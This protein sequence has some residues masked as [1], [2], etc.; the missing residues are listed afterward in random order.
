MMKVP[1]PSWLNVYRCV[2]QIWLFQLMGSFL[3]RNRE[4]HDLELHSLDYW[5]RKKARQVVGDGFYVGMV[6]SW[7]FG[8]DETVNVDIPF[9]R[10]FHWR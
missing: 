5:R 6:Y 10:S 1:S 2:L 8:Y 7:P 4:L 3:I 9:T